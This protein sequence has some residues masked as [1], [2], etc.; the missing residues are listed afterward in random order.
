M[1]GIVCQQIIYICWTDIYDF[2]DIRIEKKQFIFNTAF[3]RA[4]I[5]TKFETQAFILIMME[6]WKIISCVSV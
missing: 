1:D 5:A 3:K 6:L 4:P 2:F